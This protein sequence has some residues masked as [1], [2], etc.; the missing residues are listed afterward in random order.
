MKKI[1]ITLVFVLLSSAALAQPVDKVMLASDITSVDMLIA[2]AAGE[3]TGIPVLIL[4]NGTLT[5]DVLAELSSLNIK[6]VILVGGPAVIKA[7]TETQLEN[8]YTVIRLWGTER[9]GTSIEVAKYFWGEGVGCAVLADD[10]KDSEADT[11]LQADASQAA[12]AD[13]CPFLPV[14][15]GKVPAEVVTLLNELNVKNATFVGLFASSEFMSKLAH[16]VQREILG[17]KAARER[18]IELEIENRTKSENATL[19]LMIIA[20]P[21]WKHVLGHGGH[22]GRHTIVRIVSSA[23]SVPRLVELINAHNI[24]DVR[25]LGHSVL[26]ADIAAQLEANNITVKKISGERASRAA[27]ESL[28]ESISRWE[29][30]RRQAFKEEANVFAKNKIKRHVTMMVNKM[31]REL[32]RLEAENAENISGANATAVALL[33]SKIDNA[34]SQL[35]AI[36]DYI[37]NDNLDTAKRRV[38]RLYSDVRKIRWLYRTELHVNANKDVSSEED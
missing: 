29:E 4:E 22:A 15:K 10:T 12:A 21:H 25:V 35:G 20:A 16:L 8:R 28:R 18:K 30:R 17:D 37:T 5:D 7:E 23:E 31:E 24:T 38:V 11:E 13:N 27:I 33:Q 6:T 19:R 3:K 26:A 36:R 9:T 14:P 2:K 1:F 34:Q 32:N